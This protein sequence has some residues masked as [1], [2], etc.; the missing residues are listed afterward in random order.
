MSNGHVPV[1]REGHEEAVS[2]DF[3]HPPG[4]LA[5]LRLVC[6]ADHCYMPF[7]GLIDPDSLGFASSPQLFTSSQPGLNLRSAQSCLPMR[8]LCA[9]T[10]VCPFGP[11]GS[12]STG[13]GWKLLGFL[14]M[15]LYGATISVRSA[16]T[17]ST[18]NNAATRTCR[19]ACEYL[20]SNQKRDK[21][22][23]QDAVTAA[24][25]YISAHQDNPRFG[26]ND[27]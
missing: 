15:P 26:H 5:A 12:L 11:L 16:A 6:L 4:T 27:S 24:D 8:M 13:I 10:P 14:A 22:W 7:G 9:T 1:A 19:R 25:F 2:S 18:P 20:Q 23:L 17:A 21:P 3:G